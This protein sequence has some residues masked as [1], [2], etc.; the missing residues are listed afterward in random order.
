MDKKLLINNMVLKDSIKMI[1]IMP[2]AFN[3][4]LDKHMIQSILHLH[5]HILIANYYI[6]W[7]ASLLKPNM[8]IIYQ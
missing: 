3:T 8:L 5:I 2:L 7:I 4:N 1:L 6:L